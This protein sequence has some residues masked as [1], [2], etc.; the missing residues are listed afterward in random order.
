MGV[1]WT[2]TPSSAAR[3][4]RRARQRTAIRRHLSTPGLVGKPIRRVITIT[5]PRPLKAPR[6]I[7][8]S[9]L[10]HRDRF[11]RQQRFIGPEIMLFQE[12]SVGGDAITFC[13]HH[14]VAGHHFAASDPS[15]LAVANDQCPRTGEVAERFQDTLGAGL[16]IAIVFAKIFVFAVCEATGF[17]GG[18]FLVM[19]FTGGTA[20]IATHLLIPGVPEGLAFTAMFAALPGSLVAAPFSLIL[21][22]VITT[23]IGALQVAPVTVAVLT[24]Y[25]AVSGSGL[26]MSLARRQRKPA[27]A[28]A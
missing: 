4:S 17:I 8:S 15:A 20:G 25:L 23:Q 27:V 5:V 12:H 10:A 7:A 3:T 28:D 16:L 19:L 14:E 24:A 22:G 18:P 6:A 11:P 1:C 9:R 2:V 26:L 21:L 13:E